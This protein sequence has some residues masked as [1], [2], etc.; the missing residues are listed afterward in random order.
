MGL[1]ILASEKG[2]G[3]TFMNPLV[4]AVIAKDDQVLAVGAHLAYGNAHAEKAAIDYLKET[5]M[6]IR[7]N[8]DCHCMS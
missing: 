6:D 7:K 2:R 8:W 4:G 1:T 3:K 5:F